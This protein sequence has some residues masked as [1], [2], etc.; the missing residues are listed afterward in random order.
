[1]KKITLLMSIIFLS[2]CS[3]LYNAS[4]NSNDGDRK[5]SAQKSIKSA[6]KK[7]TQ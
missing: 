4:K 7:Q 5:Y 1:M 3:L 6:N 2:S